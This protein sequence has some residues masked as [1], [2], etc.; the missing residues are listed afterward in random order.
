MN[1]LMGGVEP[2][3]PRPPLRQEAAGAVHEHEDAKTTTKAHLSAEKSILGMALIT[4]HRRGK[5][6]AL[7]RRT[8]SECVR[9]IALS[10]SVSRNYFVLRPPFSMRSSKPTPQALRRISNGNSG[11]QKDPLLADKQN[12]KPLECRWMAVHGIL[13]KN[14]TASFRK[15]PCK[16]KQVK[17]QFD[18]VG[19]APG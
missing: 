6:S 18:N 19:G 9:G 17:K 3:R 7:S 15:V 5:L 2:I 8:L 16:Q 13:E 11:K 10:P 14:W 12:S 4:Q 1:P